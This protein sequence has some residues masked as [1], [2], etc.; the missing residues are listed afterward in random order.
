M[1]ELVAVGVDALLG[2]SLLLVA[3][4]A[5]EG[6][7]EAV[8]LDGVEQGADLQAV[9]R[10]LPVIDDNAVGDGVV[11]AGDDEL[12]AEA[13]DPVVTGL[14]HLG[15]VQAGVDLQHG[16]G[17]LRRVEGLLGQSEHHD[18]VLA[19]AEHQHRLLELRRDLAED[20]DRLRLKLVELTQP[21]VG[22]GV[23]HAK[24]TSPLGSRPHR[25]HDHPW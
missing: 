11:D 8:L 24:Q 22:V 5:A 15:E 14:Q 4:S 12:D 13:V 1:P 2:A 18:G 9:A 3:A 23:G 10:G 16:E 21:V 6:G 25:S 17:D 19:A 7:G 20:V